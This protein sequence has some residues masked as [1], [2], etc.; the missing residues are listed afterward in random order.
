MLFTKA[1]PKNIQENKG[2]KKKYQANI[3]QMLY[4]ILIWNKIC[5]V[6][7]IIINGKSHYINNFQKSPWK[8]VG[9]LSLYRYYGFKLDIM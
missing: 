7:N 4:S 6:R 9:I 3:M 1:T 2:I 5:F 8:E